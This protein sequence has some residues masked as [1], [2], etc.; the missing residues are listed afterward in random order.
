MVCEPRSGSFVLAM[1]VITELNAWDV[2]LGAASVA[3]H[4]HKAG[5]FWRHGD[6][7]HAIELG[8]F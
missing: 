5:R 4:M 2:G 3:S 1:I 8:D 6:E 7:A